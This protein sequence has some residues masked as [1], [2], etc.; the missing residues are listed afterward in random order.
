MF[1]LLALRNKGSLEGLCSGLPGPNPLKV[2]FLPR[3]KRKRDFCDAK[4]IF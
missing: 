4:F 1:T 2:F 3:T